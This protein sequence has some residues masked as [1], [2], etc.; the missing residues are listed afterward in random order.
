VLALTPALAAGTRLV[1]IEVDRDGAR[2]LGTAVKA[3]PFVTPEL[4]EVEPYLPGTPV[5][6][7]VTL[8]GAREERFTVRTKV[9]GL[10]LSH[11]AWTDP[12]VQGDTIEL[13]RESFVVEL[14][15][16]GPDDGVEVAY[17]DGGSFAAARRVIGVASLRG[18][19]TPSFAATVFWPEQ[20]NDPEVYSFYGD[21]HAVGERINIVIIPDGY[22]YAEK[23]VMQ[24]HARALVNYFR[25][26]TP[27]KEH[28]GFLNYILVYAYSA[29]SGTDQC[30][31]GV[32][33]DT[34]M[35]SRFPND[36]YPCGDS[37]NRCL[38]YGGLC[39]TDGGQN[40][41]AAELRAPAAD[42]SIVMVNT[43]RYG[44]CGGARAVYAAGNGSAVEI[45][46]HELG[47]S[48]GDL[49]DEYGGPGCGTSAFELNTSTNG[50]T[51]AWPEWIDDIGPPKPGGQYFD[52]CIYRPET[53]CEMRTL[54]PAFCHVCNQ[55]WGRTFFGHP[56][57]APTAPVRGSS[58]AAGTVTV[59]VGFPVTF[60]ITTR[61][62]AGAGITNAI[63]W[64]LRGNG[65]AVIGSGVETIAPTFPTV[66]SYS[67][68]CETIADTNFIKKEKYGPNRDLV[69]WSVNAVS[70]PVPGEV[71]SLR[72][73][74]HDDLAWD[75]KSVSGSSAFNLYRNGAC[76][77]TRQSSSAY[78]DDEVPQ[79]G[80]LW[81]YLVTGVT[82]SGEG[83]M[84]D[85]RVN[86]TPC[87]P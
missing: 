15:D 3:R 63:T 84:G 21:E 40:L 11:P 22:T 18:A 5:Q 58:P 73:T 26:K 52:A 47:H 23:S 24:D 50:V 8:V 10:C 46:G 68:T 33:R 37:G 78:I 85:A 80:G 65:T 2:V 35:G 83:P 56:R 81:T 51:G 62:A 38:F 48:L 6:L 74:G 69:A 9:A 54:G 44:G 71:G 77:A 64:T 59:D 79:P 28:D 60:G 17:Y 14:P 57:V 82:S 45:A 49:E 39:D 87:S 31:C 4:P 75:D 29:Q 19:E 61:L 67:L 72:F 36:G 86:A 41:V 25:A 66:R 16:L 70:F 43:T 1:G 27:Y 76:I 30:D 7:E 34:A 32:V 20:F 53:S 13:H 42:K 12:H 55:Q